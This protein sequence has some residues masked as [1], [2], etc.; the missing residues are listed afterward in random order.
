MDSRH[1]R[2]GNKREAHHSE[3]RISARSFE[4]DLE[5]R[6]PQLVLDPSTGEYSRPD[7][8]ENLSG[9]AAPPPPPEH[10]FHAPLHHDKSPEDGRGAKGRSEKSERSKRSPKSPRQRTRDTAEHNEA[11]LAQRHHGEALLGDH[12]ARRIRDPDSGNP[13]QDDIISVARHTPQYSPRRSERD[14]I[15]RPTSSTIV[16]SATRGPAGG[17]A[18]REEQRLSDVA[19][20]P[21]V[22]RSDTHKNREGEHLEPRSPRAAPGAIDPLSPRYRVSR[23]EM[24]LYTISY[25]ILFSILGTLARV[26]IQWLTFY[27]GAPVITP[28]LW[29][30]F[31]G[32]LFLGFLSEDQRLFR[33]PRNRSK[34]WTQPSTSTLTATAR[35]D[36][37]AARTAHAKVKKTIPLYVGLATGFCGSLTSFSTFM[38]DA[39]LALSN[40]LP[41]PPS[42]ASPTA[43]PGADTLA[44]STAPRNGGCSVLAVLAVVILTVSLSLSALKFGAHI[45]AALDPYTPSLS[46]LLTSTLLN[47]VLAVLA[48]LSWLGAL[49]L[50]IYPPSDTWRGQALFALLFA[51]AGCLLRHLASLKLNHL[52]KCFPLG[53][54]AVN[55]FGTAVLGMA[56]DLQH[57]A[58]ANGAV[59][60]G[61]VGCQVLQGVQDGFCGALTTVSTWV[62]ELEGLGRKVGMGRAWVYGAVSVG[63]GLG[64]VV[65]VM[66][67]VRWTVG[68]GGVVCGTS[69]RTFE[70]G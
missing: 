36:E 58:L 10:L 1:D 54:F 16:H 22:P 3:D 9:L 50:S 18:L 48:W 2:S 56:W 11:W 35:E 38:R 59:G 5:G 63:G 15:D 70:V 43:D 44:S 27:P 68:F 19:A 66:G 6:L 61:R 12:Q 42:T 24:Q 29:S 46:P 23:L 33:C 13:D 20:P 67:S 26:G 65:V 45:A 64:L 53:T 32:S 40:D 4:V 51:P 30:N 14:R 41:T 28:V 55:I 49:L 57:V 60:G 47:R 62:A 31:A 21:P 52:V 34:K 39:F 37:A 69:E 7:T 8:H 25:L 17:T